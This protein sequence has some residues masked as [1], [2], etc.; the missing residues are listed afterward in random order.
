MTEQIQTAEMNGNDL[1]RVENMKKY[2]PVLGGILRRPVAWVKAVDGVTF[3]IKK[4][5]TLGLVGESGCGK[6]TVGQTMLRLTEATSGKVHFEGADVLTARGDELKKIRRNMQ[7]VFQDPYASLD[8]R[9]PIGES[10]AEGLAIHK[11]GSPKQ[12]FEMVLA[13]LK[14]VGLEDYHAMR[15]PHE[16]SGGQRQRIGIARA[17]VLQPKFI[18][19]DEPV[20]ALDVS[21]QAQ[22]LN[23]LKDLQREFGL[24]YLFVA[25]NLAVVEH[26]SDRVAVMYLGKIVE[27]SSRES[28]FRDPLHPYTQALM[29]AIPVP[30]PRARQ[31]KQAVLQGDVPS[32]LNP[33]PG[34]S[35][36]P[37][38]PFAMEICARIEPEL[39]E[40]QP[41]RWVHCWLYQDHPEK[42]DTPLRQPT[43]EKEAK[44]AALEAQRE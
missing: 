27:L 8:P 25:H 26:I 44:A 18:V 10:I 24:T 1:V 15:Y 19:L 2:F 34:C 33:P 5:E 14:K 37:R 35:F 28:L 42:T 11:I 23:I 12:R 3:T 30:N 16:F 17:L 22:V 7:I 32:P 41:G 36:H 13:A 39:K 21:I 40:V 38:C 4:G 29:S 9:L 20:S 6:T 43:A 31:K